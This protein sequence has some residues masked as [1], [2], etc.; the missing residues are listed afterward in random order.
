M[1]SEIE[2]LQHLG[3]G[4][5]GKG[6]AQWTTKV[7]AVISPSALPHFPFGELGSVLSRSRNVS[8]VMQN[9]PR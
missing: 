9:K 8:R 2:H 5:V 1:L 3:K 4:V 7:S 6:K